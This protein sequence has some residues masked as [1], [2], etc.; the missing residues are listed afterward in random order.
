[1]NKTT[2]WLLMSCLVLGRSTLEAFGATAAASQ[3]Q[4]VLV[5]RTGFGGDTRVIPHGES[6][7]EIVGRDSSPTSDIVA[8]LGL[9]HFVLQ[10]TGGDFSKRFT[11]IIPEPGNPKN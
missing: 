10:Y 6:D 7:D 8:D 2:Q 3:N 11:K 9:K 4:P 1:M 5:F